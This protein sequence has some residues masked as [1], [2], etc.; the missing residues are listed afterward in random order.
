MLQ[1]LCYRIAIEV[2][3][4]LRGERDVIRLRNPTEDKRAFRRMLTS[5]D[6]ATLHLPTKQIP[7]SFLG[8]LLVTGE[9]RDSCFSIETIETEKARLLPCASSVQATS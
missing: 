7:R 6:P 2:Q 5:A 9:P 1:N 3:I 8:F 4:N